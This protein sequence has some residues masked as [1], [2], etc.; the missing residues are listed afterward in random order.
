VR[1]RGPAGGRRITGRPGSGKSPLAH[2]VAAR[3]ERRGEQ[4][5]VREASAF[6]AEMIPGRQP[7]A[8]EGDLVHQARFSH[9]HPVLYDAAPRK[10]DERRALA[11]RQREPVDAERARGHVGEPLPGAQGRPSSSVAVAR[12]PRSDPAVAVRSGPPS[13]PGPLSSSTTPAPAPAPSTTGST[14]TPSRGAR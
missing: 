5:T 9:D 2:Q 1:A 14:S 7:S 6:A 11:P 12:R 4:V 3:L 10:N 13:P 8:H